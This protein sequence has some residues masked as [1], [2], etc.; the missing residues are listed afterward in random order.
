MIQSGAGVLAFLFNAS[1][2]DHIIKTDVERNLLLLLL[3]M[4]SSDE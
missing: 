3:A 4:L 1:L 2:T